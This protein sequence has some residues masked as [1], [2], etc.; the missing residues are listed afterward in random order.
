M[1]FKEGWLTVKGLAA[2]GAR[3]SYG[4]YFR[5]I[6]VLRATKGKCFFGVNF[7]LWAERED[8]PCG[9]GSARRITDESILAQLKVKL[10]HER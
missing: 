10:Y 7:D 3:A 5:Y 6:G 8:S 4:R 2:G 1:V 9:S